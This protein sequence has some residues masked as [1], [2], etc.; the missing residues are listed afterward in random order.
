[1]AEP[2]RILVVDDDPDILASVSALLEGAGFRTETALNGDLGLQSARKNVPDLVILDLFMPKKSGMKFFNEAK[3][4]ERLKDVPIVI[5]SGASSIT[6]VDMKHYMTRNPLRKRKIKVFGS[7]VEI[8]PQAFIEK[9]FEPSELIE[10]V[11][12]FL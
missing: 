11:K 1:M 12:K 4:D 8:E 10:T 5:L 7:E 9:P 6:G 2:K 3:T